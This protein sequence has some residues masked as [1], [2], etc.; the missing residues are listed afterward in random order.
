MQVHLQY[1]SLCLVIECTLMPLTVNK[2]SKTSNASCSIWCTR[3]LCT[4][5]AASDEFGHFECHDL[6]YIVHKQLPVGP[7]DLQHT[8]K[9]LNI[10]LYSS[11]DLLTCTVHSLYASV[12]QSR[13]FS[14][15]AN[16]CA[17]VYACSPMSLL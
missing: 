7:V 9:H 14:P 4:E 10:Y 2:S 11:S 3:H 12:H 6:A 5:S 17:N 13:S 1:V 16:R 15:T 8:Y